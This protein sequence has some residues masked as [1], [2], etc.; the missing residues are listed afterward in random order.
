MKFFQVSNEYP[1]VDI[2]EFDERRHIRVGATKDLMWKIIVKDGV[3][4]TWAGKVWL[5][6]IW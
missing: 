3:F 2:I 1:C 5:S 6:I 4:E